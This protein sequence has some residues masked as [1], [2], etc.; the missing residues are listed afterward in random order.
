M[1]RTTTL[2]RGSGHLTIGTSKNI[3]V[4]QDKKTWPT[5]T[6]SIVAESKI[7]F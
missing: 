6:E 3:S 2:L 7:H 4:S 5:H 1:A